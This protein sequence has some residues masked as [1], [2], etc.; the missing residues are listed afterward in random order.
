[1][2]PVNLEQPNAKKPAI[3][4]AFLTLPKRQERKDH[5]TYTAGVFLM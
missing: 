1:M 4:L 5:F 3:G 2:F